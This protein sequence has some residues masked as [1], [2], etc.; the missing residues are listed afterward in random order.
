VWAAPLSVDEVGVPTAAETAAV[1]AVAVA[2]VA[3]AAGAAG[4]AGAGQ[5]AVEYSDAVAATGA[6]SEEVQAGT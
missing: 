2:A 5:D 3:P 1:I 4:P 6:G